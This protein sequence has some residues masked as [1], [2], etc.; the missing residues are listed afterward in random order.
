MAV[1]WCWASY[2]LASRSQITP[3]HRHFVDTTENATASGMIH[4][5]PA[6]PTLRGV[7]VT[8]DDGIT[9]KE[10]MTK[11]ASQGLVA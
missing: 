9:K 4:P 7:W 5:L 1:I 10:E 6:A 8:S 3:P 11:M 2:G